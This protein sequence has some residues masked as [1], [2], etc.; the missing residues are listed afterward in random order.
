LDGHLYH[1]QSPQFL[2]ASQTSNE[3]QNARKISKTRLFL[4][5][6]KPDWANFSS[7][8]IQVPFIWEI[9]CPVWETR[10]LDAAQKWETLRFYLG[11]LACVSTSEN[12]QWENICESSSE[13]AE[14]PA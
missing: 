12:P 1:E 7:I 5:M 14:L 3:R 9:Q 10:S 2:K 8:F 13:L 11:D 4:I 6:G